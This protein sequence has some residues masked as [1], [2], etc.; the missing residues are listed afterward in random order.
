[1]RELVFFLKK[2]HHLGAAVTKARCS[3]AMRKLE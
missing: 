3:T 2:E 1:M